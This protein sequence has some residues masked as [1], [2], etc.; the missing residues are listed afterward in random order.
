MRFEARSLSKSFGNTSILH[1]ASFSLNFC[2]IYGLIGK[3]G[4]GKTTLLRLLAGLLR[5]DEGG[6]W[7]NA[8]A[9][10]PATNENRRL[11]GMLAHQ[12][13]LYENL[14]AIENLRFY[15]GLY[16]C[17]CKTGTL[18]NLLDRVGLMSKTNQ[19]VRSFSR[20]MK[21][22]LAIARCLLHQPKILLLDEPF[23][24][25]D[26]EGSLVLREILQEERAKGHFIL[27]SVHDLSQIATI[28]DGCLRV[29]DA[30]VV[31]VTKETFQ[32]ESSGWGG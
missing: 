5:P 20:G 23:T 13:W 30:K 3:N 1:Q 7:L 22:R 29:A 31:E 21:Q 9:W 6:F 26:E 32:T 15:Q 24:G 10:Q 19:V 12:P 25:L 11:I 2:G 16:Q 14:T 8:E 27:A 17:P 4:A 18:E 28:A